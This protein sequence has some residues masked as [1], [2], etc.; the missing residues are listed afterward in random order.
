MTCAAPDHCHIIFSMIV[1]AVSSQDNELQPHSLTDVSKATS[2][3]SSSSAGER[4]GADRGRMVS[5]LPPFPGDHGNNSGATANAGEIIVAAH[6][7]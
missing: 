5:T 3:T 7:Q 4:K 2:T 1:V 6:I